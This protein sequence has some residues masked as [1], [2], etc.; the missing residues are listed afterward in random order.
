MLS[1]NR[2]DIPP[3]L[4]KY[5]K[6][7]Q[8]WK[9]KDD[10]AIPHRVALALQS[11][12]WWLRSTIIWHKPNP[13]PSSVT[14]RPTDSHEYVFLLAKSARYWY[15]ADA[16]RE[17]AVRPGDVQ[18]FGGQ[19]GRDYTPEKNDP[20]YRYGK[21][22]WGRTVQTG[23]NG[24][25]KRTVWTVATE[26]SKLN[27]YAMFPQALIEPMIL[28]GCPAQV[29]S[30]CGAGYVR[31]REK[32]GQYQAHWKP[33]SQALVKEG[34]HG[35]SGV[36]GTGMINTYKTLGFAPSCD[37][38]A[39]ADAGIVLDPFI[40]TGTT[41]LVAQKHKRHWIGCDVNAETVDL[42]NRR[43]R[44]HGDDKRMMDEQAAGVEQLD[45]FVA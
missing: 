14:D 44:Y 38:H 43:T 36:L 15:D 33:A 10:L 22:Q 8:V 35:D 1:M 40:G 25:N 9:P 32:D 20:N 26:P 42:A 30:A 28:A 34:L 27:H 4:L 17:P 3:H 11:R 16:I 19:K 37:C 31:E 13:M 23:L 39:P 6:P 18:T 2:K 12:G 21:E 29:C 41:A 5:F 24:A 7:R 45:M